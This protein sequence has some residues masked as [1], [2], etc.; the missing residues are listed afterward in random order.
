M[1][2]KETVD[3]IV[4]LYKKHGNEDYIGEPVSQI[5]HMCQCAQLA[6]ASG[7][8]EELILAA[9]FHDIG[10]LCEFAYPEKKLQYMDGVGVVDHEKLGGTYL[11][12]KGFSEKIVKLVQSHVEAKRYLTFK[13]PEYFN[14]LSEASIKTLAFQGGV[15][16]DKEATIF[17]SDPL[18]EMYVQLRRWDEQAKE[19]AKPLPSL[20]HYKKLMIAHLQH[21]Q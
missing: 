9:F 8:D 13:Y 12:S 14:Q 20:D 5:E 21:Q 11:L 18:H 7:G 15:M 3:E 6:E 1:Q 4:S 17:E 19:I 16:T 2:I 10:H